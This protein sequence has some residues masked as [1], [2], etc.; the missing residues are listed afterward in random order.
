MDN[1]T[2]LLVAIMFVTIVVTGIV[3]ILMY[4]SEGLAGKF[5]VVPLHA[6]W[7]VLLLLA[8]LNFF[9]HTTLILDIEGWTFLYFAGFILG[10]I[11][12]LFASSQVVVTPG[13]SLPSEPDQ[14]FSQVSG[15]FF[16]LMLLVQ[17]WVIGLDLSFGSFSF[18]TGLEVAL[19]FLYGLLWRVKRPWVQLGGVVIAWFAFLFRIVLLSV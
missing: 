16:F 9:W 12:L 13:G 14:V 17:L 8:Y 10:P 6:S 1:P 15:R 4:L 5:E 3:N 7:V 19:A 11:A 2:T 18:L